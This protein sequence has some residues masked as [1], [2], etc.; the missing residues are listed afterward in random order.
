MYS[1]MSTGSSAVDVAAGVYVAMAAATPD[2]FV[3]GDGVVTVSLRRTVSMIPSGVYGEF[4]ASTS[5]TAS[6]MVPV[7]VPATSD[8]TVPVNVAPV[9][10]A[11]RS[12]IGFE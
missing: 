1:V 9:G 2:V 4:P 11:Y 8:Q 10:G 6:V 5:V 7:E 3:Y 12:L